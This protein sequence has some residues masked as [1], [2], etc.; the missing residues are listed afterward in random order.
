MLQLAL[1]GVRH[2]VGR[3][4]ATLI[5]IVTGVA[6]F[7]AAGFLSQRVIDALEGN[8]DRQFGV[9]DVAVIVDP[10]EADSGLA[11]QLTI[12]GD[13]LDQIADLD[14]VDAVAGEL[15]GPVAFADADGGTFGEGTTGRLWVTDTDL[16]PLE[17]VE[18]AGPAAAGEITVDK[19]LA[20]KEDLAVG[21]DATLLSVGGS[22]DVTIVGITKFGSSDSIDQAGTVTLASEEVFDVLTGGKVEYQSAY[23]RGSA[24]QADLVSQV[25]PLLPDGFV[26]QTGDEFRAD[27][28]EQAGAFGRALKTG[29]QA[30]AMLA[31]LVGGFVIY[32]TFSVIIAQRQREL[33]V[34]SAIGATPKQLKRSLRFEGILVGLLGSALGVVTGFALTFVLMAVLSAFGV[35]L[36]GS[37]IVVTPSIVIQGLLWGTIITVLSVMIPARRAAKIEPIEAL[38]EASVETGVVPRARKVAALVLVVLGLLGLLAASAPAAIGLGALLLVVGVLVAGPMIALGGA[39]LLR[40]VLG[41]LGLEGQLA[42]DNSVR[43]PKRTATTANALVIGVFLVTFVTVAGTSLKDFAVREIQKL[44]SADF[45]VSSQGG[46]LDDDL[47]ATI[48]DTEGVDGVVAF[49]REAVT[50]DGTPGLVS[51]PGA[52]ADLVDAASLKVEEGSLDDLQGDTI[53]LANSAGGLGQEAT[54]YEIGDAVKVATASGESRTLEVVALL[55]TNLDQGQVGDLVP[56][57]VFEGLFADTAPTV[58]FVDAVDGTESDT[59]DALDEALAQRPDVTV[60]AG[61]AIGKLIGTIF[62]FLINAINGLLLMSVVVALIGIVNT[63]SLSILERRRELGLLRIIGMTDARVQRMVRL[64]SALIAALGTITGVV[65]GLT[66]G[67]GTIFAINRSTDAAIGLSFPWL[68]LGLVIVLGVALGVLASI[69]PARRSTKLDVLDAVAAS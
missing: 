42:V 47:L 55:E 16:N 63:L 58:A 29:L 32:N 17:L 1:R 5:A 33:A 19:G 37:G 2:N 41:R 28:R 68:P 18:G 21:D 48:A 35:A 4:V 22:F 45:V 51:T 26:A 12:P 49:K 67:W 23:A 61:N 40:P 53:A 9:V 57:Q 60:V 38:R 27:Q 3:Y 59:Q 10:D 20:D 36:P 43:S 69:I 7:T 66:L 6:F 31:L 34:L 11:E 39:R 65:L 25:D 13:V 62:D 64:E 50:I 14:G 8:V 52:G 54:T 46:S 30:F 15:T 24:S 56:E 44:E